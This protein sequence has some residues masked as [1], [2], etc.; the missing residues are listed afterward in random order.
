MCLS[1]AISLILPLARWCR[2]AGCTLRRRAE[3]HSR[4]YSTTTLVRWLRAS[5]R[6][7]V[8][9]G[10]PRCKAS[11]TPAWT[12]VRRRLPPVSSWLHNT[13]WLG[14][15][16]ECHRRRL[17]VWG[18][19]A[20]WKVPGQNAT[21]APVLAWV[22]GR[23]SRLPRWSRRRCQ[24]WLSQSSTVLTALHLP[25][26]WCQSHQKFFS[27]TTILKT[28]KNILPNISHPH[29]CFRR[30]FFFLTLGHTKDISQKSSKCIAIM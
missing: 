8:W 14:P 10:M 20:P 13:K 27:M 7:M 1:R 17:S 6:P 23:S 3:Q 30:H 19:Q 15:V 22:P 18:T 25:T 12:C 21:F 9:Q 4:S 2:R 26:E 24:W 29:L 28:E 11:Y 16:S 5:V